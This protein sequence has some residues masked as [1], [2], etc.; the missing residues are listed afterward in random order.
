LTAGAKISEAF[1]SGQ[2]SRAMD[3]QKSAS[4]NRS[5]AGDLSGS[6]I[7]TSVVLLFLIFYKNTKI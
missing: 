5:S 6:R 2:S 7:S 4:E 3:C 1:F